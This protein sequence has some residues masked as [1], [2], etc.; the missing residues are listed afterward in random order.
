M[1]KNISLV[2]PTIPQDIDNFLN[3]IDYYFY[4]L[5]INNIVLICN[6]K[7]IQLNLTN[8]QIELI[9]ESNLI[10]YSTVKELLLHRHNSPEVERRVGWY[11]QQFLKMNFA[12]I[13]KDEYYLLWDSDTVPLKTISLFDKEEIPFLDC[14]KEYH[15]PYFDTLKKIL[16][17]YQKRI[18]K[19]FIAEHMLI[20][21][22][23]MCELLD[24]IEANNSV[25]GNLFYEKIINAIALDH[26]PLSGFSE[27]ETYGTY[28]HKKYPNDYSLR[29]WQSLRYGGMFFSKLDMKN[30]DI[31][32]WLNSYYDAIS[33]EKV[34]YLTGSNI[35]KPLMRISKLGSPRLLDFFALMIRLKRKL[36]N[37]STI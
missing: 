16:P 36:F 23:H 32:E 9:D 3:N 33:F 12:R 7:D 13:C 1:Y 15:K 29:D 28:V 8:P 31:I 26:L 21:T 2:V 5:P 25:P 30:N 22:S 34:H 20:K 37:R 27:F 19:S 14:K 17:G 6:I 10:S 4:R 24:T 35:L 11:F 18:A